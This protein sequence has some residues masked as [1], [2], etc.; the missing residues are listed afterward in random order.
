MWINLV[1]MVNLFTSKSDLAKK[2]D[3]IIIVL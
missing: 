3:I 1:V 2:D